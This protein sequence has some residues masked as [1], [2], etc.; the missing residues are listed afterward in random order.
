MATPP[1]APAT[2]GNAIVD[3]LKGSL[4]LN[5]AGQL[6]LE[7][8]L[9]ALLNYASTYRATMSQ[10]NRDAVDAIFVQQLQD[11]QYVWRKLLVDAGALPQALPP[12][13]IPSK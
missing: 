11:A 6:P 8:L 13:L 2:T 7:G 12:T 1:T 10:P 9:V 5:I 4:N 3:A